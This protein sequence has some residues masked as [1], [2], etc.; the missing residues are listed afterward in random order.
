M[1]RLGDPLDDG[2]LYGPLH[3]KVINNRNTIL[4]LFL[5]AFVFQHLTSKRLV[6]T[7]TF[8]QSRTQRLPEEQLS[9]EEILSK[10]CY[11]FR[12]RVHFLGPPVMRTCFRE[13]NYVEPT[14]VTGL[15]HDAPVVH[16]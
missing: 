9:L 5:A 3:S 1:G 6:L 13:G 2:T 15:P 4:H 11:K 14:I 10:G 12:G 8:K 7:A 16:R